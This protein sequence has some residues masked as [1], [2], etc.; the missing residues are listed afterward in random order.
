[1]HPRLQDLHV[2]AAARRGRRPPDLEWRSPD[3]DLEMVEVAGSKGGGG[4]GRQ[5]RR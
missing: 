2:H 4:G 5:I 1:M 3:L